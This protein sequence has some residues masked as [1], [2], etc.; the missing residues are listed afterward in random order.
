MF[1]VF[2]RI[3]SLYFTKLA[4]VCSALQYLHNHVPIVIHGD[5]KC[6][7]ARLALVYLAWLILRRQANVLVNQEG[8]P[9]LADF[10]LASVRHNGATMTSAI[11]GGSTRWMA[12]ELFMN[13]EADGSDSEEDA[14]P[15]KVTRYSDVWSFAMLALELLTGEVPF[16][17]KFLDAAVILALIQGERPKHPRSPEVIGRGLNNELWQ[18]L[19][20]CWKSSPE[21]RLSLRTLHDL[22][23]TL[24]NQWHHMSP[25]TQDQIQSQVTVSHQYLIIRS[26]TECHIADGI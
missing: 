21:D 9:Y 2:R 17:D 24:A 25:G 16:P 11:E 14:S 13:M 6:V 4:Q 8:N 5:I 20:G 7:C 1:F 19:C 23:N 3:P 18:Y 15:L 22:L 26:V 10:G 12:P